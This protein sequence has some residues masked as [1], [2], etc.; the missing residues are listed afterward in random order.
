M[1]IERGKGMEKRFLKFVS[2]GTIMRAAFFAALFSLCLFAHAARAEAS[3]FIVLNPTEFADTQACAEASGCPESELTATLTW[4]WKASVTSVTIADTT[5]F[6]IESTGCTGTVYIACNVRLKFHPQKPTYMSTTLSI[7]YAIDGKPGTATAQISGKGYVPSLKITPLEVNFGGKALNSEKEWMFVEIENPALI[8]IN[9]TS[10]YM[11]HDSDPAFGLDHECETTLAPGGTCNMGVSFYPTDASKVNQQLEGWVLV[12]SEYQ[13][14]QEVDLTGYVLPEDQRDLSYSKSSLSFS[15]QTIGSVSAPQ[16]F[17]ITNVGGLGVTIASIASDSAS[18]PVTHDCPIAPD[19][20][21]HGESCTV[22][23]TFAPAAAGMHAGTIAIISDAPVDGTE[24]DVALAGVGLDPSKPSVELSTTS[25]DFGSQTINTT[26]SKLYVVLTNNGGAALNVTTVTAAAPFAVDTDCDDNAVSPNGGRCVI[27]TTFTPTA[28]GNV[29]G[30]I[31]INDDAPDTPQ[32]I[33]LEGTGTTAAEPK[34][35]L[36]ASAI[37][38]GAQAVGNT[39]TQ[40]LTVTN[41]GNSDLAIGLTTLDGEGIEAYSKSD[42][43]RSQTLSPN[44]TCAVEF[45]F[46]PTTAGTVYSVSFVMASNSSDSPQSIVIT[47]SGLNPS[48]G[49]G[50]CAIFPTPACDPTGIACIA[51]AAALLALSRIGRRRS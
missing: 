25:L 50:S 22:S 23:T 4:F 5:N 29:T 27:Q 6:S 1:S 40:T 38:F 49:G 51:S 17:T 28:L 19:T 36:S 16:T 2:K 14:D 35:S 44:G 3:P 12:I 9:V 48:S 30:A 34:A 32:T 7:D 31:T 18:F 13:Q 33:S 41:T 47:G 11:T 21:E 20:I 39:T 24:F 46:T 43:C 15:G 42:G 26:S 10:L 45:L 8:D 37:D